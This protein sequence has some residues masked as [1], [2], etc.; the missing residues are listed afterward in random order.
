MNLGFHYKSGYTVL[1][2]VSVQRVIVITILMIINRM[3]HQHA[4]MVCWTVPRHSGQVNKVVYSS[5]YLQETSHS[6]K[7]AICLSELL[8]LFCS[9]H[10]T[11][12]KAAISWKSLL[13]LKDN[14]K[15]CYPDNSS[16]YRNDRSYC[17]TVFFG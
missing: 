3:L 10:L 15:V 13:K 1:L 8:V 9:L 16:H 5:S 2:S 11:E 7:A 17:A 4:L 14:E 12:K 6:Q